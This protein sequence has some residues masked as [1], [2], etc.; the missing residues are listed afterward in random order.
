M[1]F[2]AGVVLVAWLGVLPLCFLLLAVS[3]WAR[4]RFSAVV[5]LVAGVGFLANTLVMVMSINPALPKPGMVGTAL[6]LVLH[7]YGLVA[8]GIRLWRDRRARHIRSTLESL[9]ILGVGTAYLL[10]LFAF[11]GI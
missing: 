1:S 11:P 9:A 3:G 8:F 5:Q 7:V 4:D 6:I 2:I 10:L